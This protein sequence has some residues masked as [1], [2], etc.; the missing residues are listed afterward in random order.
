MGKCSFERLEAHG[1]ESDTD[2]NEARQTE[3]PS[4]DVYPVQKILQPPV[5]DKVGDRTGENTADRSQFNKM[6]VQKP[7]DPGDRG[8]HD[9]TDTDLLGAAFSGKTGQTEQP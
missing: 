5:H 6:A 2:R 3:Y 7:G 9:L 8:P 4:L 1:Q